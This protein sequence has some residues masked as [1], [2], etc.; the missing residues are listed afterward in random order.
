MPNA[1]DFKDKFGYNPEVFEMITE[2]KCSKDV[3]MFCMENGDN[4]VVPAGTVVTRF[5]RSLKNAWYVH[6]VGDL[7]YEYQ[8]G[9]IYLP[10]GGKYIKAKSVF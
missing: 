9:M 6:T 7:N 2:V 10:V 4:I 5:R 1:Q 3:K 8:P